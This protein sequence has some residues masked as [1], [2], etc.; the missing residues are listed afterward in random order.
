M[1]VLSWPMH[2]HDPQRSGRSAFNGPDRPSVRWRA[3]ADGYRFHQPIVGADGAIA[4]YADDRSVYLVGP[5]G[6]VRWHHPVGKPVAAEP[7]FG[8]DGTVYIGCGD[9]DL[10]VRAVSAGGTLLWGEQWGTAMQTRPVVDEDGSIYI[11]SSDDSVH[12]LSA[13]GQELWSIEEVNVRANGITLAG[14]SLLL[15]DD[16]Q[17]FDERDSSWKSNYNL[18]AL[19]LGGEVLWQREMG[20]ELV[21]NAIVGADGTIYVSAAD[22]TFSAFSGQGEPLWSADVRCGSPVG[23]PAL[24][25]EGILLVACSEGA[26]AAFR[27]D[28][29]AAWIADTGAYLTTGPTVDRRGWCYVG[30]KRLVALDP[31]GGI[32]WRF[33]GFRTPVAGIAIGARDAVMFGADRLYALSG[34]GIVSWTLR[35]EQ[36]KGI[37]STIL[38]GGRGTYANL[39]YCDVSVLDGDG[40]EVERIDAFSD[41]RNSPYI[42]HPDWLNDVLRQSFLMGEQVCLV[43]DAIR[44]WRSAELPNEILL[45]VEPDTLLW[46]V[47]VS[48]AEGTLLAGYWD[49]ESSALQLVF[50][51]GAAVQWRTSLHSGPVWSGRL[52]LTA[53]WIEPAVGPRG[54]LFMACTDGTVHALSGDGEIAWRF[55]MP[56]DTPRTLAVAAGSDTMLLVLAHGDEGGALY[57]LT[58]EGDLRWRTAIGPSVGSAICLAP[59]GRICA[60]DQE[61]TVHIVTPDGIVSQLLPTSVRQGRDTHVIDARGVLYYCCDSTIYAMTLAGERLW[62]YTMGARITSSLALDQQGILYAGCED[63]YLYA[64]G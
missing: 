43:T 1:D 62:G 27:Q 35:T 57:A 44:L 21:G 19:S 8:A 48:E 46:C 12:A 51:R 33:D 14:R 3:R 16:R 38:V 49:R 15:Q 45:T 25:P 40:A 18:V 31:D 59:D 4:V 42:W 28:G 22:N 52:R 7:A 11:T 9:G 55:T 61:G 64:L 60:W 6:E 53:G 37:F 34:A 58:M 41:C 54:L 39:G 63:G 5:D 29:G 30:G 50:F 26:V 32:R 17:I 47:G 10:N 23:T 56:G 24:G 20:G 13:A 36:N 2:R